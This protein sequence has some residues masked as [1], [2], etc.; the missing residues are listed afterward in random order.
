MNWLKKLL[1]EETN[2]KKTPV[3]LLLTGGV[4]FGI[5][6]MMAWI[7]FKE[8]MLHYDTAWI[9]FLLIQEGEFTPVLGRYGMALGQ[10]LPY[11]LIKSGAE[12]SLILKS[13]SLFLVLLYIIYLVAIGAV[14]KD[15]KGLIAL[16]VAMTL[17]FRETFFY[18]TAELYQGTALSVVLWVVFGHALSQPGWKRNAGLIASA[19]LVFCISFF[20]PIGIFTVFFVLSVEYI[21]RQNWKDAGALGVMIFAVAWYFIR[22]KF[23]ITSGYEA[24]RMISASDLVEYID[25]VFHL[26]STKYFFQYFKTHYIF[27]FLV[28]VSGLIALLLRRKWLVSSY[29]AIYMLVFWV[30]IMIGK[31]EEGSPIMLQNYYTVFGFFGGVVLALALEKKSSIL[32]AA[33]VLLIC[34]FSLKSIY[35]SR[36][37]YQLRTRFIENINE[38]GQQFP[39]KKYVLEMSHIPWSYSWMNWALPVGSMMYSQMLPDQQAVTFFPTEQPDTLSAFDILRDEA[40]LGPHFSPHWF[41]VD[42]LNKNY[43]KAEKGPYRIL[44]TTQTV[45]I[46]P[47]SLLNSPLIEF[48]PSEE[49][50]HKNAGRTST[51]IMLKNETET[52]IRSIPD[53]E[54][55][56]YLYYRLISDKREILRT[57]S[58]KLLMDLAP[59]TYYTDIL[60]YD[61][62][63]ESNVSME[64]GFFITTDS[65]Y[66]PKAVITLN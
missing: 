48:I 19:L 10:I 27:P 61:H 5:M 43:F 26:P 2:H 40:F 34:L 4:I 9:S 8:R 16:C 3:L 38:Y 14:Y 59:G 39:E 46:M 12:L 1:S 37:N 52:L 35:Q 36:Y 55:G 7:L 30:V 51:E 63:A 28:G 45:D 41:S 20:H 22:I 6:A 13:Y 42:A 21:R 32:Q 24:G 31:R 66:I 47:D 65:I 17:T 57:E 11:I 56:I 60:E 44:N 62:P 18:T 50:I 23:F 49:T 33:V 15:R 58:R 54:K 25:Q 64:I 53:G 29:I